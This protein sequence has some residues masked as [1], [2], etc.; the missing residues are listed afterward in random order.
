MEVRNNREV[1]VLMNGD[2][3][4]IGGGQDPIRQAL[5]SVKRVLATFCLC[6]HAHP[7]FKPKDQ[8]RRDTATVVSMSV[9]GEQVLALPYVLDRRAMVSLLRAQAGVRDPSSFQRVRTVIHSKCSGFLFNLALRRAK[10]AGRPNRVSFL[11]LYAM[12]IGVRFRVH[13]NSPHANLPIP[14]ATLGATRRLRLCSFPANRIRPTTARNI[15][16]PR[17]TFFMNSRGRATSRLVVGVADDRVGAMVALD[18]C[19]C[20]ESTPPFRVAFGAKRQPFRGF[21]ARANVRVF[22][23][24]IRINVHVNGPP[25]AMLSNACL[26]ILFQGRSVTLGAPIRDSFQT[27]LLHL[28]CR[29]YTCDACWRY[30]F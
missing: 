24:R 28:P 23:R 10:G 14:V 22:T 3:R 16:C 20:V 5:T 6:R 25:F 7:P 13:A 19:V 11:R 18:L 8:G 1:D 30:G 17:K 15:I 2:Q 27:I 12:A 21:R 29:R 26:V 4:I 9:I